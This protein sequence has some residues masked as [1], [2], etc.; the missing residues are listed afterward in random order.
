M[1][2]VKKTP[3]AERLAKLEAI[4]VALLKFRENDAYELPGTGGK[5]SV[6]GLS[7]SEVF[8]KDGKRL[9]Q[10]KCHVIDFFPAIRHH[11]VIFHDDAGKEKEP[12]VRMVYEGHVR[13][14][15]PL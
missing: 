12:E 5:S 7:P 8:D 2:D 14:W 1:T 6:P 4:P 11:R 3:G 15:E 10:T 9:I 13:A